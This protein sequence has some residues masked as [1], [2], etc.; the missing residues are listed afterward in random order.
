MILKTVRDAGTS[1]DIHINA[2]YC[3]TSSIRILHQTPLGKTDFS[4]NNC[5]ESVKFL[6]KKF[7]L[8]EKIGY[9]FSEQYAV[10]LSVVYLTAE[11]KFGTVFVIVFVEKCA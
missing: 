10:Y 4:F 1:Q 9:G 7:G 3:S 8:V 11:E 6:L 5:C 2:I